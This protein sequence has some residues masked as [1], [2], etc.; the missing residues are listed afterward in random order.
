MI[1]LSPQQRRAAWCRPVAFLLDPPP[2]SSALRHDNDNTTRVADVS[3]FRNIGASRATDAYRRAG[4]DDQCV[5]ALKTRLTRRRREFRRRAPSCCPGLRFLVTAAHNQHA[6][7]TL[8]MFIFDAVSGACTR[9]A[10]DPRAAARRG[11]RARIRPSGAPLLRE[12]VERVLVI[13]L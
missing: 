9:G 6:E 12:F 7:R 3:S 5:R 13:F 11:E 10:A 4:A 2:F 8:P 1:L